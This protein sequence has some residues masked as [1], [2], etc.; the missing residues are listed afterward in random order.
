MLIVGY[1][2]ASARSALP[3]VGV[4]LAYRVLRASIEDKV[5]D[6]SAFSH[7]RNERFR[8]SGIFRIAFERV[9]GACIGLLGWRRGICGGCQSDRCGCK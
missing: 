1:V 3:E 2:S 8:D 9:V 7:A 5:P 6:H 4:N